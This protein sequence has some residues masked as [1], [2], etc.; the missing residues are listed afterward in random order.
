MKKLAAQRIQWRHSLIGQLMAA[1]EFPLAAELQVHDR[2]ARDRCAVGMVGARG[3][4]P[5]QVA[6]P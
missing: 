6:P 3:V 4:I 1:G 2:E 5:L